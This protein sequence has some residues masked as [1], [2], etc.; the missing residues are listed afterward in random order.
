MPKVRY[1]AL[2]REQK[3]AVMRVRDVIYTTP[4]YPMY[5]EDNFASAAG[6]L[7]AF[8]IL[9]IVKLGYSQSEATAAAS[10]TSLT[11]NTVLKAHTQDSDSY[12]TA[13][14][15]ITSL[16]LRQA[17]VSLPQDPDSY[18]TAGAAI[19]GLSLNVALVTHT[20]TAD[21]FASAS[22]S[23]TGLTLT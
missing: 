13:D 11:L 10:V 1:P 19:T 12:G 15:Q 4:A 8:S 2:V 6:R 17:L 18:A 23:I 7:T 3:A 21:S 16:S 22:A 14:A 9:E 5:S 20:Q